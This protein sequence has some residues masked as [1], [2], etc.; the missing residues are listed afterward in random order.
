MEFSNALWAYA[1]TQKR[2]IN[3]QHYETNFYEQFEI[4]CA[5]YT[6]ERSIKIPSQSQALCRGIGNAIKVDFFHDPTEV[7]LF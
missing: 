4:Y 3:N 7:F 5:T 1:Q 2:K 6:N